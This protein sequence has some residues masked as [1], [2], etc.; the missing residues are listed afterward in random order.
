M[1]KK[2]ILTVTTTL[3]LTISVLF[4]QSTTGKNIDDHLLVKDAQ[5]NL[6]LDMKDVV[7]TP[8]LND[9]FI[10]G[11]IIFDKGNRSAP[12]RYNIYEDWVEYQENNQTYILDPDV[13]IRKVMLNEDIFVVDK[14]KAKGKVQFGYFKLLDSGKVTLLSKQVVL[15]KEY[16]QASALQSNSS[17]P[18][19]TRVSDQ[20]F[21]KLASGELVKVDNIKNMIVN[22][23]DNHDA[24]NQF[25]KKEKIS[26]LDEEDL[27]AL[28]R[29][30]N[31][32]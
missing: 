22:F 14:Y 26:A 12:V 29:Y 13:R 20:F 3:S 18:K 15:F 30:Y 24:L 2:I 28:V 10:N 5:K 23:P 4:G 8:Y 7:G 17:P 9:N 1:L 32:L 27:K 6:G 25:A 21:L 11:E 16:Q 19:Y 31:S